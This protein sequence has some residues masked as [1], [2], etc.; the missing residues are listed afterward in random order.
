MTFA[1]AANALVTITITPGVTNY[2]QDLA[3]VPNSKILGDFDT[4]F[5]PGFHY[6]PLAAQ[7]I[8]NVP[9][10]TRRPLGDTT[11]YGSV[12]PNDSPAT[13]T[14]PHGLKSFSFFV[15][16]PDTFNRIVFRRA[17]N[18]VIG[19]LQ[20]AAAFPGL[21][22]NGQNIAR[23]ITYSFGGEKA[24]SVQFFSNVNVHS[25]AFEYDRFAGVVPEPATWAMMLLG[26]FGMGSVLRGNRKTA[27]GLA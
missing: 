1:G 26:F 27:L 3:A 10:V 16:S 19:S 24:A 9:N 23:R 18:T 2:A 25:F 15:G 20:G 8:G 6:A 21:P 12:N 5:A 7:A 22:V 4:I 13:F 11:V 17:N 14:T